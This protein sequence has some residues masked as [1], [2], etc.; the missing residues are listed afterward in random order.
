MKHDFH[1]RDDELAHCKVCNGAEASLPT[2]C[3]GKKLTSGEED[4][5]QAGTLDYNNGKW[6]VA[7]VCP[8]PMI[9]FCPACGTQHID[10][11]ESPIP[12]SLNWSW[13]NPPHRSHLCAGCGHIWR[14]ADV[15]TEGVAEIATK[16]TDDRDPIRRI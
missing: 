14:P 13:T 5:I 11:P 4:M 3:P 10:E 2:Q 12:P 6:W 16:G 1:E 9:L 15:P 7:T 8:I